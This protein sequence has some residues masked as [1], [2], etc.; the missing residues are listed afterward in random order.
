MIGT[1]ELEDRGSKLGLAELDFDFKTAVHSG[2]I[3]SEQKTKK[4]LDCSLVT[5]QSNLPI[6]SEREEELQG[7]WKVADE[8]R[9]NNIAVEAQKRKADQELAERTRPQAQHIS[10]R[11]SD[12]GTQYRLRPGLGHD[13]RIVRVSR[14]S[15]GK[16]RHSKVLTAKGLRDRRVRLSVSTAIQFYD[17]QDRLGFDQPSKA[18][19]WLIKAAADAIDE[20]PVLNTHDFQSALS[21]VSPSLHPHPPGNSNLG[22]NEAATINVFAESP[23]I[24]GISSANDSQS[25]REG[26]LMNEGQCEIQAAAQTALI[27]KSSSSTSEGSRGA[28]TPSGL[29]LSRSESRVKARERAKERAK[30]KISANDTQQNQN[31]DNKGGS[32]H[33][34]TGLLNNA[35]HVNALENHSRSTTEDD[36]AVLLH[37]RQRLG[38]LSIS[39]RSNEMQHEQ[40]HDPHHHHH[41]HP[42][43][44][45]ENDSFHDPQQLLHMG[46]LGLCSTLMHLAP[47]VQ[48]FSFPNSVAAAIFS[49]ISLQ[50]NEMAKSISP[51]CI[52]QDQQKHLP[53][54]IAAFTSNPGLH[55]NSFLLAVDQNE[56]QEQ[57]QVP[58]ITNDHM[59]NFSVPGISARETLQSNSYN[60]SYMP[61]HHMQRI[62]PTHQTTALDESHLQGFDTVPRMMGRPIQDV[63]IQGSRNSASKGNMKQEHQYN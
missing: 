48:S 9:M 62:Q 25:S 2:S 45:H 17:L 38:G 58:A 41:H 39:S 47:S 59:I 51:F 18:V 30:G 54:N 36:D 23:S 4:G 52:S 19:E 29:S 53:G 43:Q 31:Q 32:C 26:G 22:D 15:G 57:M 63:G 20:L 42:S 12:A 8:S 27:G 13:S 3:E 14:S 35:G 49:P 40:S 16:D 7:S 5:L 34:F 28:D 55:N 61:L 21:N 10:I 1:E 44:V 11:G 56:I 24:H 6:R 33:S 60:M 37:K 50:R 46:N